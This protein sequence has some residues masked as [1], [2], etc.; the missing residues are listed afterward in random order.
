LGLWRS[1]WTIWWVRWDVTPSCCLASA[2]VMGSCPDCPVLSSSVL[3]RVP[4]WSDTASTYRDTASCGGID[5]RL[6]TAALRPSRHIAATPAAPVSGSTIASELVTG[7]GAEDSRRSLRSCWTR[8]GRV[9]TIEAGGTFWTLSEPL[10]KPPL[11]R[12]AS[13]VPNAVE[14]PTGWASE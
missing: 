2:P 10:V 4:C 8:Y 13:P 7:V 1:C 12:A 14:L 3:S 11:V 9:G 6:S 5:A